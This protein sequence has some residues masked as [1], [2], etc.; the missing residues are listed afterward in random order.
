MSIFFDYVNENISGI[1]SKLDING[2]DGFRL[3]NIQYFTSN[4]TWTPST[5]NLK[6]VVVE[7]IGGGGAGGATSTTTGLQNSEGGGG[8]GGGYSKKIILSNL[9]ASSES[10]TVGLGG[11]SGGNGETSSFGS[12]LSS[13]GGIGQGTSGVVSGIASFSGGAGGIGING[14]LNIRG[15][16]GGAQSIINAARCFVN[17][18][19]G[20]FLSAR[21][22]TRVLN[23]DGIAGN[24]PGGG[25]SGSCIGGDQAGRPGGVGAP[26]LVIVWEYV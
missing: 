13:E 5:S 24:F 9:L 11:T 23:S 2:L 6:A 20:T 19:G 3:F 18:G 7:V 10:V 1:I 21:V 22:Y 4:G 17:H 14:D 8:G 12:H 15:G 26:G 25:G 16:S